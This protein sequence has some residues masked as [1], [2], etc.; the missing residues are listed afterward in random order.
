MH[1]KVAHT[2]FRTE[3]HAGLHHVW[4]RTGPIRANSKR[5]LAS[6]KMQPVFARTNKAEDDRVFAADGGAVFFK[7]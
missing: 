7:Q 1:K 2:S 5:Q 4:R 6:G 3:L